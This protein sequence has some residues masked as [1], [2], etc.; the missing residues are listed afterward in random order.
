MTDPLSA[1][2]I[3]FR[4][5]VSCTTIHVVNPLIMCIVVY[6]TPRKKEIWIVNKR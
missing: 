4:R 3:Y 1:I 6:E 5:R 2:H